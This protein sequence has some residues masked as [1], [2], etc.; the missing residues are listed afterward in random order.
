[1]FHVKHLGKRILFCH[2]ISTRKGNRC[3]TSLFKDNKFTVT[4]TIRQIKV[5]RH[6]RGKTAYL[7]SSNTRLKL[8]IRWIPLCNDKEAT[9]L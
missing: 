2:A 1:M 5:V 4:Q 7:C 9:V 3:L 8:F 6:K